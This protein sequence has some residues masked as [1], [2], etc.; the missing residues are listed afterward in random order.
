MKHQ[1]EGL[2]DG[3]SAATLQGRRQG[4]VLSVGHP[5]SP[6]AL[7]PPTLEPQKRTRGMV[8]LSPRECSGQ[9]LSTCHLWVS[10]KHMSF[11]ISSSQEG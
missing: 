5:A 10:R 9:P 8:F 3:F 6:V 7:G 1:P 11:W 4:P 2:P